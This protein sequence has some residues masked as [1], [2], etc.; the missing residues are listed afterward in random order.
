MKF[1]VVSR[2]WYEDFYYLGHWLLIMHVCLIRLSS[3][4]IL[5]MCPR[6]AAEWDDKGKRTE[7]GAQQWRSAAREESREGGGTS[8]EVWRSSVVAE[9]RGE[10]GLGSPS[11]SPPP[12]LNPSCGAARF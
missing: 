11:G 1:L 10:A 7:D 3:I 9:W 4:C 12:Q 6:R 5:L 2:C 8:T